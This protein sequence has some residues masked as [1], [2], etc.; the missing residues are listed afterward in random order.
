MPIVHGSEL[1]LDEEVLDVGRQFKRV[2]IR[3]DDVGEFAL[4]DGPDLT[5]EAENSRRIK[6]DGLE[7][8]VIRQAVR[9]SVRGVLSQPTREGIIEARKGELHPG[10]GKLR[11][12]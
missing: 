3:H 12:L 7:R 6:R 11:G 2:A 9:D 10:S 1:P 4:L 8:F 5:V